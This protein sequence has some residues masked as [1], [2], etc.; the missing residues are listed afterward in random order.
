MFTDGAPVTKNKL[1]GSS[2]SDTEIASTC[3]SSDD[4]SSEGEDLV[5][6][7]DG[8]DEEE[9]CEGS[10]T[11]VETDSEF[12]EDPPHC[13]PGQIPTIVVNEPEQLMT[14]LLESELKKSN[15]N[16]KISTAK[17][18][19]QGN[20]KPHIEN[21]Y[22]ELPVV[23]PVLRNEPK[24][25]ALPKVYSAPKKWES[26]ASVDAQQEAMATKYSLDLKQKYLQGAH[27]PKNISAKK[28]AD[29]A[30]QQQF[31]S[32]LDMISE[33]QKL[34]Q[35]ASKP[36]PSMQ[37][38][39]EGA[40]KLKNKTTFSSIGG[41]V[42]GPDLKLSPNSSA[43]FSQIGNNLTSSNKSDLETITMNLLNLEKTKQSN[44]E[45]MEK[46]DPEKELLFLEGDF[47]DILT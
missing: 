16:P 29:P 15:I 3:G 42:E 22:G 36:S 27:Q 44:A 4:A 38:F 45:E 47:L 1:E 9:E 18:K 10:T 39:L 12:A 21:I 6:D 7:D 34:L 20:V 19:A 26:L 46:S 43:I 40:E 8:E 30:T 14:R 32:V 24:G 33:K 2:D 11:E 31:T 35:P 41:Y 28:P 5:E 17:T 25:R 23:E 13:L 37:A